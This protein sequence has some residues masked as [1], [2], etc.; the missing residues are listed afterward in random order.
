MTRI[1]RVL[2]VAFVFSIV[3]NVILFTVYKNRLKTV[4]VQPPTEYKEEP[5]PQPEIVTPTQPIVRVLPGDT[6]KGLFKE[7][8]IEGIILEN[9][10]LGQ[11]TKEATMTVSFPRA[12]NNQVVAEVI[13]GAKDDLILSLYAKNFIIGSSQEWKARPVSQLVPLLKKGDPIKVRFYLQEVPESWFNDSRCDA[14]CKQ[15]LE[16]INSFYEENSRF[17]E[18]INSTESVQETLKI[19]AISALVISTR[20]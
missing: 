16:K 11:K 9:P 6:D 17:F 12:N 8:E 18:V 3:L 20:E 14:S 5:Q 4:R 13:L 10:V 19:G 2:L 7:V 15:R 1:K